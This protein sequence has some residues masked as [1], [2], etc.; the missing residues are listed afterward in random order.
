M[1]VPWRVYTF[2]KSV[3]EMIDLK[4]SAEDVTYFWDAE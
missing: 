4:T 2:R 1:L 3:I